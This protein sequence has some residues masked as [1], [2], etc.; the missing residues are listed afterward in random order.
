MSTNNSQEMNFDE[1]VLRLMQLTGAVHEYQVAELIHFNR[2]AFSQRKKRN[3]VPVDKIAILCGQR[4]WDFN[5]VINGGGEKSPLGLRIHHY[6]KSVHLNLEEFVNLIGINCEELSGIESQR[7]NPT[8][9]L[10]TKI[11]QK[12][13]I[14]PQ[15]LYSEKLPI[16]KDDH[17]TGENRPFQSFGMESIDVE[18]MWKSVEVLH[19]I[20]TNSASSLPDNKKAIIQKL[21]YDDAVNKNGFVDESY[22]RTLCTLTYCEAC[23][24]GKL[25]DK[26][27]GTNRVAGEVS[28]LVKTPPGLKCPMEGK[29]REYIYDTDLTEVP[30]TNYYLRLIDEG[31]LILADTI[32]KKVNAD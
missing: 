14:N 27:L 24:E 11:I 20:S 3:S 28:L 18:L 32:T 13:D 22:A 19:S 16:R 17:L 30:D 31:S 29:P 10:I 4:G 21:L 12:T 25:R 2:S 26:L 5:W 9:E 23:A 8:S 1:I 7:I 6:R 15:W